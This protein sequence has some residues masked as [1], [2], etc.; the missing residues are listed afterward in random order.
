[1][2]DLVG[3]NG[4]VGRPL[5]NVSLDYCVAVAAA[6]TWTTRMPR[7]RHVTL[8]R[9]QHR[10]LLELKDNLL[11]IIDLHLEH[12]DILRERLSASTCTTPS[13]AE[14]RDF[15]FSSASSLA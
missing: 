14:A 8:S 4:L 2:G 7:D 9:I 13:L 6:S 5:A 10:K 3:G 12:R 1:M 15:G 11:D